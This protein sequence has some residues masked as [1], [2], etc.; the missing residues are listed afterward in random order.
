M[1]N[2]N[3]ISLSRL[4]AYW[5][6]ARLLSFLLLAAWFLATFLTVF[7]ARELAD[8]EI[9]GWPVSFYMAAQ[10]LALLYLSLIG[11]YVLHMRRLDRG[12]RKEA[13]DGN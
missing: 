8:I 10:G 13:K 2:K 3:N 6:R 5:P 4:R 1:N 12:L 9:F 7:F 11:L